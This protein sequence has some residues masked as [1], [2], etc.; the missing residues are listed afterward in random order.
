[1]YSKVNWWHNI[2]AHFW[3]KHKICAKE[4]MKRF[5]PRTSSSELMMKKQLFG[6]A[7]CISV[8]HFA[9][10]GTCC[11]PAL[12]ATL[13]NVSNVNKTTQVCMW[14]IRRSKFSVELWK[15]FYFPASKMLVFHLKE[16]NAVAWKY[17]IIGWGGADRRI[18][19]IFRPHIYCCIWYHT[20]AVEGHHFL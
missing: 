8:R 17:I 1:M 2:W 20:R 14:I 19:Y 16:E 5:S 9:M 3:Q 18:V 7:W 12:T 10:F 6:S 11:K 4:N 15:A 13:Q